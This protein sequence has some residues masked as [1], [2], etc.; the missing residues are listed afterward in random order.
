MEFQRIGNGVNDLGIGQH[1]K[2]DHAD[3]EIS[4][5]RIDLCAQEFDWRHMH[6]CDATRVLRGQRGDR[7]QPMYAE[8]SERAQ[9]SLD[10]GAATGIAAGNRQRAG[11]AGVIQDGGPS[12]ELSS[13]YSRMV[14]RVQ[15]LPL[16]EAGIAQSHDASQRGGHCQ[17]KVM[18]AQEQQRPQYRAKQEARNDQCA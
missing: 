17:R 13:K 8:R 16:A 10:A 4:E 6:C 18:N 12:E 3:F 7:R 11:F 15:A 1:A 2:L 14:G 9:V 5:A